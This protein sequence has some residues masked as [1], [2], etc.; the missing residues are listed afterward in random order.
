MKQVEPPAQVLPAASFLFETYPLTLSL[1]WPCGSALLFR[2]LYCLQLH[3]LVGFVA[4]V[5]EER[6]DVHVVV[7]AGGDLDLEGARSAGV[8]DY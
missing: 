7:H 4:E 8:E 6:Q 1:I 2:P 3:H 5:L